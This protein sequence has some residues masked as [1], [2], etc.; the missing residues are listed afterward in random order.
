[1]KY[2]GRKFYWYMRPD[3]LA[4]RYC[5]WRDV[6]TR[7]KKLNRTLGRLMVNG[8]NVGVKNIPSILM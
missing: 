6:E 2:V 4:E 1:M 3:S 7:E 5:V 8:K